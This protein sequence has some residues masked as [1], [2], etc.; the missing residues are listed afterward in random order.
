MVYKVWTPVTIDLSLYPG[1]VLTARFVASDCDAGGHFG[2]AYI[3]ASCSPLVITQNAPLCGTVPVILSAP[4]GYATY[5]WLP[6]G[7]TTDSIT[8]TTAG[9]YSVTVVTT[10]GCQKQL[11]YVV[12]QGTTGTAPVIQQNGNFL[13]SSDSVGIQWNLNGTPIPGA[14]SQFYTPSQ[15]GNYS[16][17][18]SGTLSCS[19]T[20]NILSFIYTG[21]ENSGLSKI[22]VTIFP[23]PST[24]ILTIDF[25]GKIPEQLKLSV[26]NA[27]GQEVY[28]KIIS[29]GSDILKVDI[30]GSVNAGLYNFRFQGNS[31]NSIYKV[32]FSKQ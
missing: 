3:A 21:I 1:Q 19:D 13:A 24:G 16:V 10:G 6:G 25:G 9:S 5:N 12:A 15:S 26:Y 28:S 11:T 32:A 31:I 23:N 18:A 30:S 4:I 22:P 2:Y 14:T 29:N 20:S 17:T 7:Q 8:I 27:L